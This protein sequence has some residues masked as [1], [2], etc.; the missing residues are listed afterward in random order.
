MKY[1]NKIELVLDYIEKNLTEEISIDSLAEMCNLSKF[2]FHRIFSAIT[3]QP[4]MEYIRLRRIT[5]AAFILLS[6]KKPI[7][8]IAIDYQFNSHEAFSRAFKNIYGINPGQ[9]RKEKTEIFLHEKFNVWKLKNQ[10]GDIFMEPKFLVKQEFKI[11]GLACKTTMKENDEKGTIPNLWKKFNK[12]ANE[13]KNCT[14]ENRYIGLCEIVNNSDDS[15]T[16]ICCKE[17]DNFNFIPNDM[18]SKLVPSSKY[19]IFTHIGTLET[20]DSTYEFIHGTWLPNS[21]YEINYLAPDFE[22]YDE[23]YNDTETSQFD[24]YIPIK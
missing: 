23:R 12:R 9:Y 7:I 6:S 1:I 19:V 11:I 15:F 17:V 2:Y 14:S 22:L 8:E 10:K 3:K 21:E 18:I 24:I 13:I 4:V 5:K 16:Y 20:L